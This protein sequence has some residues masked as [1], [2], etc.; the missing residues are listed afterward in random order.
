MFYVRT[1]QIK[2][3]VTESSGRD[4]SSKTKKTL[5]TAQKKGTRRSRSTN[6]IT[7][8]STMSARPRTN[9][10]IHRTSRSKFRTPGNRLQTMSADRSIMNPVTPKIHMNTP[11]SLLRYPKVGETIISMSGSPVIVNG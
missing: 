6:G 10:T 8:L 2:G 11:V 4:R 5:P 9:S 7:N 3:Y 1:H